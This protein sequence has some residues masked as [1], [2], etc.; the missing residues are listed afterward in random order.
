ML[1]A[2][3]NAH[4]AGLQHEPIKDLLKARPNVHAC[5]RVLCWHACTCACAIAPSSLSLC[6]A[7]AAVDG[8][9]AVRRCVSLCPLRAA[10]G[11]L[12]WLCRAAGPAGARHTNGARRLLHA[13]AAPPGCARQRL[14]VRSR[15]RVC[16]Q[17]EVRDLPK[18]LDSLYA[19]VRPFLRLRMPELTSES[20]YQ[21][22]MA[23]GAEG[24]E[25]TRAGACMRWRRTPSLT[26]CALQR[27]G[28]G[29]GTDTAS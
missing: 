25:W 6:T 12:Y 15:A 23:V 28:R 17:V 24:T 11:G 27:R 16:M 20:L 1:V 26:T 7:A 10:A 19:T 2:H 22:C 5:A 9:C 21:L 14:F 8:A 3:I 13:A 29:L 18:R 4:Q